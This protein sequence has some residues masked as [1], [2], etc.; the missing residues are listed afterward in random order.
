MARIVKKPS[1][2]KINVFVFDHIF[3]C[4]GTSV[5]QMLHSSK[6]HTC[7]LPTASSLIRIE[8]SLYGMKPGDKVFLYGH[9][10]WG[11]HEQLSDHYNV[12]YFTLLRNPIKL[13]LST[14][15]YRVNTYEIEKITVDE[16]LA[17]YTFNKMVGHLGGSLKNAQERIEKYAIVG[18]V[19]KIND[20]ISI[21][22]NLTG[23][24]FNKK[25]QL[26]VTSKSFH[27]DSK[28]IEYVN[29]KGGDDFELYAYKSD[30]KSSCFLVTDAV[31]EEKVIR[32]YTKVDDS[33]QDKINNLNWDEAKKIILNSK[34]DRYHSFFHKTKALS[35]FFN[36]SLDE[37]FI[38]EVINSLEDMAI[39]C[40]SPSSVETKNV[41]EKLCI[42]A[43]FLNNH[44]FEDYTSSISRRL[45]NLFT[46]L[47]N[48]KYAE[49]NRLCEK[50]HRRAI[51]ISD[52]FPEPLFAYGVW[53]R[54]EGRAKEAISVLERIK[55]INRDKRF[56]TEYA[57][58][59]Y[60]AQGQDALDEYIRSEK[61]EI[62]QVFPNLFNLK[63]S[64]RRCYLKDFQNKRILI[65]RSGPEMVFNDF[66]KNLV[67]IPI[68][69]TIMIQ[70]NIS[71]HDNPFVETVYRIPSG[72]FNPIENFEGKSQI[73]SK[74]FDSVIMV[75]TDY[76]KIDR[77]ANFFAF[78]KQ[79]KKNEQ[80]F[81]TMDNVFLSPEE[82][83]C[84]SDGK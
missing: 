8:D 29:E 21:L 31:S 47:G 5:A 26:N 61:K 54:K 16:Y 59:L 65:I 1:K 45:Q 42:I 39:M 19:E 7:H 49:E 4:A 20:F 48:T 72:Q 74:E 50:Y 30:T 81:Y 62:E 55:N 27:P 77:L 3:K 11:V 23:T 69:L 2:D 60:I 14:Y 35:Q 32:A 33:F 76:G 63:T 70:E 17:T 73:L 12:I 71:I 67:G 84:I 44:I 40:L 24:I 43:E 53:L 78:T 64:R 68:Q 41:F 82:K 13:A 46:F 75:T 38:L 9:K 22:S 6:V 83:F 28:I 56:Y 66:L 58:T 10:T 79:I 15:G 36:L 51:D 52:Q 25:F 57:V 34:K 18:V 37:E 80:Y